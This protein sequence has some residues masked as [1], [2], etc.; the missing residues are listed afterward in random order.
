MES[1]INNIE[2]G[3]INILGNE[4]KVI[5]SFDESQEV[6]YNGVIAVNVV[7]AEDLHHGQYKDYK[8]TVNISGQTFIDNDIDRTEIKKMLNYCLDKLTIKQ[9]K[10]NITN[11]VGVLIN[12]FEMQ[13]D[14]E[15]NNFVVNMQLYICDCTFS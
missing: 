3:L 15:T 2:N 13:S 11:C 14:D 9:I 5:T 7:S 4:Y 12:N 8:F 1:T 6:D 10:T